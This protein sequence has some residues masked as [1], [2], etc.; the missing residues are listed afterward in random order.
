MRIFQDQLYQKG[1]QFVRL[2]RVERHEVEFKTTQGDPKG[3][4]ET[5][6]LPKKDF[7]RLIRGMN[8]VIPAEIPPAATPPTL[9]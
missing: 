9:E 4:G 3:D 5:Q 6:I 2:M 7:C 8:L 1:E